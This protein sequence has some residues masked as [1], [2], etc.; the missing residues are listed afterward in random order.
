MTSSPSNTTVMAAAAASH[1]EAASNNN[2]NNNNNKSPSASLPVSLSSPP[3]PPPPPLG[4]QMDVAVL[5]DYLHSL[6]LT[7]FLQSLDPLLQTF[8]SSSHNDNGNNNSHHDTVRTLRMILS[9]CLPA[10]TLW[11]THLQTPA[12]KALG[13]Q[14]VIVTDGRRSV[15][16][17]KWKYIVWTALL[18]LGYQLLQRVVMEWQQQ[19]PETNDDDDDDDSSRMVD[20]PDD[21]AQ[22]NHHHQQRQQTRRIARERQYQLARRIVEIIQQGLPVVRLGLLLS[23]LFQPKGSTAGR[24]ILPPRLSMVL[25][26][27]SFVTAAAAASS[28]S[29]SSSPATSPSATTTTTTTTTPSPAATMRP[30]L[31]VLYAHRR[32]LYEESL[33]TFRLVFGPLMTSLQDGRQWIE[34]GVARLTVRLLAPRL[35]M[36]AACSSRERNGLADNDTTL[37]TSV[38]QQAC[39]LCGKYPIIIPY[40]TD[41]CEHVF[42][43]TCL[44]KATATTGNHN[45][46]A[47]RDYGSPLAWQ[48][49]QP[50]TAPAQALGTGYPCPT[51]RRTI[52]SSRPVSLQRYHPQQQT[53]PVTTQPTNATP[54]QPT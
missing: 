18:P 35:L 22:Q 24:N 11:M 30:G 43:Y 41:A 20:H 5:D 2:N 27:L 29:S 14:T 50:S 3:P 53:S 17:T 7:K 32:W 34:D 52:R 38:D 45:N 47:R 6:L 42:C 36:S 40:E 1:D 33:H 9:S 31:Y 13:L 48:Q 4:S 49:T 51:C 46:I 23:L 19:L 21:A 37:S 12:T 25:S 8:S 10:A 28:T 26:G 16:A 15:G 44:W 39:A 54:S